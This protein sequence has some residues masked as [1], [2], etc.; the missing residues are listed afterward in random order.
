MTESIET[1]EALYA[2]LQTHKSLKKT[3][4]CLRY[5]CECTLNAH[6][7]GE[8]F[9]G[10]SRHTMK[11]DYDDS[12]GIADY[13]PPANLNKWINQSMLNQQCERIVLQNRAV[14]ENIGYVPS[15][16]GTNP[17]GGKGNENLMYIDIQPIAKETPPEEM[18]PT[19]I[20]YHRT[21]PA[22]IKI[23]WYMRP[24]MHQ[25]TF[26]NRSLRGMSFYLMWF[27]LTLIA[28]AGLLIIIVGVALKTDHLTLWQLLYLSIPMGYF[29]LV[30][31]YVTLPLFRLPEYRI[32]KA[33]PWMIAMN[34]SSA[35]I[36]MHRDEHSQITSLTQF[37]GECPICSAQVTLREGWKDQRL[38]LV[39]RCR[40][41]P[42]DH[43][44]SF[45]RVEMTGRLL[46]RR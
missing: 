38:P 43:V 20:R 42:F 37:I 11:A 46:T 41:S 1:I 15:I 8:E 36:E 26:R 32:L 2:I 35:E 21:P 23:A 19:S 14:F 24:F 9:H 25:G 16:E 5:L 10:L 27:L 29:Y 40:E 34:Q 4:H 31:H 33:P 39:G 13:V 17:Q 12:K 44:Y 3:D 22:N 18:D 28:L 30:M 7:K 6:Q 45:D